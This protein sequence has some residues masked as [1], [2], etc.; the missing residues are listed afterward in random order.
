LINKFIV[1]GLLLI[2][3]IPTA[4][5][6]DITGTATVIDGDTLEIRGTRIWLHGIDA[7]ESN[8]LS[9]RSGNNYRYGQQAAAELDDLIAR[10]LVRCEQRDVDRYGRIVAECSVGSMNLNNELVKQG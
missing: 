2:A 7:P 8:Q 4:A 10:Q 5:L 9:Q 1:V 3:A 6:A